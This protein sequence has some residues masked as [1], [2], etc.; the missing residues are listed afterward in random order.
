MS[1]ADQIKKHHSTVF[2]RMSIKRRSVITGLFESDWVDISK[3]VKKWGTYKVAI[4]AERINKFAFSS[5]SVVMANDLG[6]YN[7][8]D[9]EASLWYNYLSQ[10]RTLVKIEAGFVE[11]VK[12]ND[13]VWGSYEIPQNSNWDEVP[14]DGDDAI[15]DADGSAT[16]FTGMISGDL[17][18][19][20]K[21]EVTFPVKPLTQVFIDYAA[22]NLLGWTSTGITATKFMQ[23]V[24]DQT[25]GAGSF[26]FRPFFGD[27]TT[28]WDISTTSV[29]YGNLNTSTAKEVVDSNVWQ[30]MEK[31][32]ESENMVPYVTKEGVFKFISR[33]ANTSTVA[34]EFF[35]GGSRSTTYGH[36]I[37]SIEMFGDK[38]SK[39]YSRVQM[40]WQDLDT[41]TAYEVQQSALVVEGANNAW[42]LGARSLEL[43]NFLIPTSTVAATIVLNIFNDV[44]ALKNE[45]AFT[46]SFIPHLEILDR[47]AIS[48]DTP[49]T[50][51]NTLWDLNNWADDNTDTSAD[52]T[53][54]R[55]TGDAIRLS[56]EEFKFLS[57]AINLDKLET[58]FEAREI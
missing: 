35:G 5:A 23:M 56:G 52:L 54:D 41:A 26:I 57:I 53:W 34:F 58:K 2:R 11:Q 25:D 10:Q 16:I 46:T 27:T 17:G 3:D 8:N 50:N 7:P 31:L 14:W 32:A 29:V 45:I 49:P 19:S 15:W 36:T 6:L 21:N 1:I 24:R 9:D 39:Y 43:E 20:S 55:Q 44:S 51:I 12:G 4:D 22:K 18:L 37:K 28:N 38:I 40:K 13:G 33:S 42:N 47:V 30:V 48:Y